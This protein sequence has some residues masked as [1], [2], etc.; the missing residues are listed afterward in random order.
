[1]KKTFLSGLLIIISGFLLMVH[2]QNPKSPLKNTTLVGFWML[3]VSLVDTNNGNK[4]LHYP[5][6]IMAIDADGH[7]TIFVYTPRGGLITSEGD[8]VSETDSS[9]VEKVI[10]NL[11]TTLNG[12]EVQIAYKIENQRLYKSFTIE[13]NSLGNEINLS[14]TEVWRKINKVSDMN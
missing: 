8:I 11:N 5:G 12:K 1:M 4:V 6:N 3:E 7:Y 14:D 9:Y 13:K 10:H 2:A